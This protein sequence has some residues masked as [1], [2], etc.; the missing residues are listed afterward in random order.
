[1]PVK[2]GGRNNKQFQV[3]SAG[4]QLGTPRDQNGSNHSEFATLRG[5][6]PHPISIPA[7]QLGLQLDWSCSKAQGTPGEPEVRQGCGVPASPLRD[8]D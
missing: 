6:S 3:A 7:E 8:W 2:P 4:E 1:M 5:Q